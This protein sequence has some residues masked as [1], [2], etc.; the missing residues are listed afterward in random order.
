MY[1]LLISNMMKVDFARKK[2]SPTMKV[3]QASSRKSKDY[4]SRRLDSGRLTWISFEEF[5]ERLNERANG[6]FQG[7][8]TAKDVVRAIINIVSFGVFKNTLG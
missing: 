1:G 2:Q 5:V 7:K 3:D 8:K 6:D 4:V